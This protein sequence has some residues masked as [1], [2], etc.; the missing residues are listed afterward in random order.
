[1]PSK[2][3]YIEELSSTHVQADARQGDGAAPLAAGAA[4][5]LAAL[6]MQ[7]FLFEGIPLQSRHTRSGSHYTA[8]QLISMTCASC[9]IDVSNSEA[10]V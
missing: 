5:F 9:S 10:F 7:S 3:K 6:F 2:N 4:L 1:M 8:L